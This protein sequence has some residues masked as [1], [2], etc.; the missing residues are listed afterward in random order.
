MNHGLSESEFDLLLKLVVDP[1]KKLGAE[2]W[3][4]GSRARG[5]HQKFSDVDIL[6]RMNQNTSISGADLG[7]IKESIEESAFSYKVD[8]VNYE[9]LAQSYIAGIEKDMLHL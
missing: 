8:I 9:E 3:L 7:L 4:F 6:F 2:V 5:T 1:L